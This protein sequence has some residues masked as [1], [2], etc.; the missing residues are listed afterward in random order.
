MARPLSVRLAESA[1]PPTLST[2]WRSRGLFAE[3]LR[4]GLKT[5]KTGPILDC[6]QAPCRLS[7]VPLLTSW[8]S[9]G[10][11]FVT[12]PLVYTEHPDRLGHNLGMY[13]IQRFDDTTTGVHWQMN[14]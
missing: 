14:I 3:A 9:D 8:H 13:R 4:L 10:G 5:V 1:A 11:A 2:L 7:E 12:L 6:R